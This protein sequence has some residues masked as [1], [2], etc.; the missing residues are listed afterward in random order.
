M[1]K[2]SKNLNLPHRQVD[3]KVGGYTTVLNPTA[4]L[5]LD[6]TPDY[7]AGDVFGQLL[8]FNAA[9]L[10]D[11]GTGVIQS[12]VVASEDAIGVDDLEMIVF[13]SN[14]TN[15]TFTDNAA[16]S[17]DV[18]DLGKIIDTFILNEASV[19][20]ATQCVLKRRNIGKEFKLASGYRLYAVLVARDTINIAN[21]DAILAANI[22]IGVLQD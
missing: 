19:V 4:A 18:A 14:P 11:G 3:G 20:G 8:T 21:A 1:A 10:E 16:V 5:D 15:T 17:I 2:Q 13:D 7:A 12:I 22:N 6:T 9:V